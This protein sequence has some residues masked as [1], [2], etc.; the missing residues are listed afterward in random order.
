[1]DAPRDA[2]DHLLARLRAR[3]D[4]PHGRIDEPG[5]AFTDMLGAL[6]IGQLFEMVREGGAALHDLVAANTGQTPAA[7]R[8]P[9]PSGGFMVGGFDVTGMVRMMQTPAPTRRR[10][11][12][13]PALV[14]AAEAALGLRLPTLLVRVYTEV[15]DGG[16][17]P[18]GGLLPLL[19]RNGRRTQ[20]L[21]E[22]YESVCDASEHGY[23]APWPRH[24]LPIASWDD[25]V[26][27]VVDTTDPAHP[28][29][30]VDYAAVEEDDEDA[31]PWAGPPVAPS[32]GEWLRRWAESG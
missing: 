1:M 6:P 14:D 11:P 15:A 32:L 4:D 24:L 12:A 26:L 13:P 18:G 3:A 27:A 16:V 17:G 29:Y 5:D 7:P 25:G 8:V 23:G 19:E 21:V 10:P 20:S 2:D 30:E 22:A 9:A 31:T 28:V